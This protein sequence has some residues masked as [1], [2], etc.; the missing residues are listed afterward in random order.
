MIGK[1]H[2]IEVANLDGSLTKANKLD[3][4]FVRKQITTAENKLKPAAGTYGA[5]VMKLH[6]AVQ[7]ASRASHAKL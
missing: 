4:A 2:T 5:K 1:S 6:R 3:E 7:D